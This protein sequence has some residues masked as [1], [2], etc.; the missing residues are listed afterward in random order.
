MSTRRVDPCCW[1]TARTSMLVVETTACPHAAKS[2]RDKTRITRKAAI[3]VRAV[4]RSCSTWVAA[5]V[6]FSLVYRAPCTNARRG[7]TPGISPTELPSHP[8]VCATL[9]INT[10]TTTKHEVWLRQRLSCILSVYIGCFWQGLAVEI[11]LSFVEICVASTARRGFESARPK[12]GCRFR[13]L[14]M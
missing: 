9:K 11:K 2:L 6:L 7:P 1:T 5:Q 4:D 10:N 14:T 8:A 12:S 13:K 3:N